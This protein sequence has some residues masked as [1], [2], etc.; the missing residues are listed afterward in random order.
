[1]LIKYKEATLNAFNAA[2]GFMPMVGLANGSVMASFILSYVLLTLFG[3]YLLYDAVLNTGCDPSGTV[4]DNETCATSAMDVF[5]ALMGVTMAAA[6]LPQIS[7]AAEAFTV[8]RGACYPAVAA[9]SRKV[10]QDDHEVGRDGHKVPAADRRESATTKTKKAEHRK[11]IVLP[12]YVIDSSSPHGRRIKHV[13][14]GIDFHNVTF[15][16]PTRLESTI[17]NGFSLRVEPGTTVALVG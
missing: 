15:A 13:R 6:G 10:G 1:M 7:A 17:F 8:A 3:T 14:G 12:K 4:P 11:S 5:G 9:I 2:A 16:Y